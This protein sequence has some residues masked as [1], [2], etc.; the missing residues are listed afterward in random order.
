[1]GIFKNQ[2]C[3]TNKNGKRCKKTQE[4]NSDLCNF[5]NINEKESINNSE[6]E[7]YNA[8]MNEHQEDSSNH[9]KESS[10]HFTTLDKRFENFQDNI[11]T[12]YS[13]LDNKSMNLELK[14]RILEERIQSY[15]QIL[16]LLLFINMY[17]LSIY[18]YKMD[19]I[20][21]VTN[22]VINNIKEKNQSLGFS[23]MFHK[24]FS[25]IYHTF[26]MYMVNDENDNMVSKIDGET[27]QFTFDKE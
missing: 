22:N 27:L 26:T 6:T 12:I 2:C 21:D 1:M 19:Y 17:F 18:L 25:V 14:Y 16:M 24:N 5:H 4:S 15:K 10:F 13:L 9:I 8:D 3:G 11:H 20:Q 7:N 23:E